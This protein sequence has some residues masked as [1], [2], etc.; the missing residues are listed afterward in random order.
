MSQ[1]GLRFALK[2]N[3]RLHEPELNQQLTPKLSALSSSK[4]LNNLGPEL[5]ALHPAG[6]DGVLALFGMRFAVYVKLVGKPLIAWNVGPLLR[7]LQ[8]LCGQRLPSV[9]CVNLMVVVGFQLIPFLVLARSVG[10]RLDNVTFYFLSGQIKLIE[11][12]LM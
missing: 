1:Q 11:K 8:H 2:T 4:S 5:R 9:F 7:R 6:Q 10:T 12:H 3:D